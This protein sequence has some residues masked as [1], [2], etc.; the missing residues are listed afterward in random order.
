MMSYIHTI[1]ANLTR[2]RDPMDEDAPPTESVF[3][4][5]GGQPLPRTVSIVLD[6]VLSGYWLTNDCRPNPL[7]FLGRANRRTPGPI[8]INRQPKMIGLT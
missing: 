8:L 4:F 3:D 2:R 5:I 7:V 1:G 6:F